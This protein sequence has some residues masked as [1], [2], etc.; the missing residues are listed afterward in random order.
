M[1][2]CNL[3]PYISGQTGGLTMQGPLNRRLKREKKK[4]YLEGGGRGDHITSLVCDWPYLEESLLPLA[5]P[6][7]SNLL[8]IY[9]GVHPTGRI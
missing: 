9:C 5:G 1:T 6:D 2:T 4:M 8:A 7:Q 3:R